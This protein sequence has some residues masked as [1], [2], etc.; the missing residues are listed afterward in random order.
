[1]N[2]GS[3]GHGYDTGSAEAVPTMVCPPE[4]WT[5]RI[6]TRPTWVSVLCNTFLLLNVSVI[7]MLV[8][9]W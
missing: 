1:M 3:L 9:P 7:I 6:Q 2:E 4:N 5:F 8:P